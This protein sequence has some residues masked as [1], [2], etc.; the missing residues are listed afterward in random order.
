MWT[1]IIFTLLTEGYAGG[2]GSTA[3]PGFTS[4][5]NCEKAGYDFVRKAP[6]TQYYF[7][8]KDRRIFGNDTSKLYSVTYTDRVKYGYQCIEVK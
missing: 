6:D 5:R 8:Q 1:L 2:L 4:L 3:I 7:N